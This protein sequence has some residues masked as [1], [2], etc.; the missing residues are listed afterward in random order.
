MEENNINLYYVKSNKDIEFFWE[1]RNEYFIKDLIPNSEL[2]DK[3]NEEDIKWFFSKEYK[4]H[5]MKLFERKVD[6][7]Y[8]VLIK[9]DKYNIGFMTYV[10]YNSEDGKCF[11]LD[12]CIYQKYRNNGIGKKVFYLLEKDFI[13]KG[14]TYI[15][16]N[17]SNTNN[18]RFWIGNGFLKTNIKDDQNNFIYRKVLK[19]IW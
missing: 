4:D 3:I 15:D 13:N 17:V 7:L 6:P 1:R 11:V 16:L 14:A 2:G 10:I 12:Y 5:I 18:E 8:I 19:T 9:K